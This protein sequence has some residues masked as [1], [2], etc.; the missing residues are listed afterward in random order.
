MTTSSRSCVPILAQRTIVLSGTAQT[1]SA[2]FK[3]QLVQYSSPQGNYRGRVGP[4]QVPA[5]LQPFIE[6]I[7][8][9]DNRQQARPHIVLPANGLRGAGSGANVLTATKAQEAR[10]FLPPEIGQYYNFPTNVDGTGQCIGI[11]EFG[12]GFAQS[13]LNTYFAATQAA[14]RRR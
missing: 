12:G 10:S 6:G 9:L 11:I 3:V 8:G 7:F 5:D 13:D 1:V 4:V 2:A 14:S